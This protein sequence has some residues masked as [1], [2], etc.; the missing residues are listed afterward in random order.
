M[1]SLTAWLI[2]VYG[3]RDTYNGKANVQQWIKADILMD[4]IHRIFQELKI[5]YIRLLLYDDSIVE[6]VISIFNK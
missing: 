2:A 5:I 4:M 6:I 1:T 3:T